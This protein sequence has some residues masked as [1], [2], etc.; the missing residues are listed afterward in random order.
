MS[1][2]RRRA[3]SGFLRDMMVDKCKVRPVNVSHAPGSV[4]ARC[5]VYF[6]L[7]YQETLRTPPPRVEMFYFWQLQFR[8]CRCHAP[9]G[10]RRGRVALRGAI[11]ALCMPCIL[12]SVRCR[13][14]RPRR[15]FTRLTSHIATRGT[16]TSLQNALLFYLSPLHPCS[17][18][19]THGVLP[20]GQRKEVA[21]SA[22]PGL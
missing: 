16:T 6:T 7:P 9:A 13:N 22:H 4:G 17:F 18:Q 19:Y 5:G 12:E 15:T 3:A 8:R 20:T 21:V 11:T 2:F 1:I 14:M 10:C